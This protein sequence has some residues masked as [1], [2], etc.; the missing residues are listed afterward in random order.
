MSQRCC[1][2]I[3]GER[4]QSWQCTRAGK[5]GRDGKWYCK[6]HDPVAVKAKQEAWQAKWDAERKAQNAIWREG[7]ALAKRLGC[8]H[9]TEFQ[10]R[11]TITFDEAEQLI[12]RLNAVKPHHGRDTR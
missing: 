7:A 9:I 11:L 3:F 1:Q 6:Q 4:V 2:T 8:G 10:R 12:E 5:V